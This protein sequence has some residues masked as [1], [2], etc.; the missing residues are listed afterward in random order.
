MKT[1][2]FPTELCG[3]QHIYRQKGIEKWL[4]QNRDILLNGDI[5]NATC[6]DGIVDERVYSN[7]K[8]RLAFLLKETNGNTSKGEKPECYKE[9]DYVGWIRD[10]Q[11]MGDEALY[12]TFRN[13]AM[14]TAEFYD[15]FERGE[16][17]KAKYLD[18]G[19]LQ[20]NAELREVLRKIAVINLKKTFGGGTTDWND[21]DS[22]LNQEVCDVLR[23]EINMAEPTVVLCGG[24]QV[25]D[26]VCRIHRLENCRPLT[27]ETPGGRLVEYIPAWD[28]VYVNF[29]HPAC[30]KSREAMFDFAADVF[31]ALKKLLN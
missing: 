7:Q 10:K 25:F 11:S 3:N 19:A 18:A 26:F 1:I 12:Q 30:R 23:E 27:I 4:L 28:M 14:W 16:T 6:Y 20:I 9:W 21:L 13:I 22:Y 2:E 24:Q 8:D 5:N 31:A 29:C 15:T 17:D